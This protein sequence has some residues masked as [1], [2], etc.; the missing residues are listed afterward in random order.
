[1][2]RPLVQSVNGAPFVDDGWLNPHG[3]VGAGSANKHAGARPT[4][5]GKNPRG[6]G[7]R[8]VSDADFSAPKRLLR[9]FRNFQIPRAPAAWVIDQCR[10]EN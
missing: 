2:N 8:G 4:G 3:S 5:R 10:M 1:M 6:C 9:I 7:A